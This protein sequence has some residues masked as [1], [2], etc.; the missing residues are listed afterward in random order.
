[1]ENLDKLP[2]EVKPQENEKIFFGD[3]NVDMNDYSCCHNKSFRTL[4]A[5]FNLKFNIE[6]TFT[7]FD[8]TPE[9]LLDNCLS[10]IDLGKID[11]LDSIVSDHCSIASQ[12]MLNKTAMKTD[13]KRYFS[14]GTNIGFMQCLTT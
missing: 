14:A 9:T 2:E 13:R 4:A 5:S 3:F 12:K 7:R 11:V 6:N 10:N 1:M 8:K